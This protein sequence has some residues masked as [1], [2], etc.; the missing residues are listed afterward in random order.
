[1]SILVELKS[2]PWLLLI[3]YEM[4]YMSTSFDYYYFSKFLLLA[5]QRHLWTTGLTKFYAEATIYRQTY[6]TLKLRVILLNDLNI[7]HLALL[8]RKSTFCQ[9]VTV[10]K[11]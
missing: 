10:I 9:K 8:I 7:V 3:I 2:M 5:H 11:D 4:I 1:M 6:L